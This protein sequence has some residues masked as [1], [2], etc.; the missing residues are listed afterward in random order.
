MIMWVDVVGD[1]VGRCDTAATL[2]LAT[3]EVFLRQVVAGVVY[4]AEQFTQLR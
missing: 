3:G 2:H 4:V 1:N